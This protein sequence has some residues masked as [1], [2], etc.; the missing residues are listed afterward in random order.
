M[1]DVLLSNGVSVEVAVPTTP[2]VEIPASLSQS[3]TVVPVVGPAGPPGATYAHHQTSAASQWTVNHNLA[4][5]REPTVLLDSAPTE[6]VTADV[7]H[8]DLNTTLILFPVPVTGW[9]YL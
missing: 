1:P 3:V 4:A 5:P 9:A 2:E 8:P 7:I 6:P